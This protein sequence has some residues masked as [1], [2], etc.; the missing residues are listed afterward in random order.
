M[1][2]SLAYYGDPILRKKAEPV[3]EFDDELRKFVKDM[4]ETMLA[5]RGVGLA[6]PQVHR[7]VRIFLMNWWERDEDGKVLPSKTWVFINPKIIE[8]SEE[9]FVGSEGCLSIPKIY[10]DIARPL[11]VTIEAQDEFGKTFRETFNGWLAKAVL[12]ENDHINGVL[13]IDRMAPKKRREIETTLNA[14]KRKYYLSK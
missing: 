11:N 10:E 13:F 12:H 3:T 8:V 2:L 7:S 5:A 6:A 4:E 14:I 1:K 9:L